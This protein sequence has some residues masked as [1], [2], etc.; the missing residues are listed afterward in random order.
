MNKFFGRKVQIEYLPVLTLFDIKGGSVFGKL[1]S[2]LRRAC[3]SPSSDM[4]DA[5]EDVLLR[6]STSEIAGFRLDSV[7]ELSGSI[8]LFFMSL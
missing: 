4:S 6:L 2:K 8:W 7:V 1:I 5:V 3:S